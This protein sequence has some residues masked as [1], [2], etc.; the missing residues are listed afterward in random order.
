M[1]K[2]KSAA[3]GGEQLE[4]NAAL[5]Q[6]RAL[7]GIADGKML[8]RVS[9]ASAGGRQALQ[10]P[11]APSG[12]DLSQVTARK[13]LDETAFFFPHLI[14]DNEGKVKL[15]FTMP[16]A[17]TQWRFLGFAH[18]NDLR[19]GYLEDKVVTAKDLMVQPN[20]PRFLREGDVLEFTVKVSN[21]SA[22]RQTGKVRLTLANARTGKPV[23]Q[24]LGI[25]EPDQSFELAA[26][27][28]QS[29]SWKLT[30]PDGAGVLTYKAVGSTGR[31][32]DGEE[33]FLPV[34]SRRTLVTES[35]P[36][37]IR[38]PATKKFEFTRLL[39]SAESKTLRNQSL[40]VQ[41]VS[42]PSW[43]AVMALPYLMESP[44]ECTEQTFNRLYANSLARHIANSD[45][46][47]HRI[48]EQWRG[49]PALQSPLEKNQDLKSVMLEETPWLRQAQAESQA[50]RNV[51]ILFEDNRLNDETA[52][53]LAKLSQQQMGDGAWPWFPG[54]PPCDYITLYITTG[55]GRLHHLGVKVDQSPA[56][57]SL[58][59]LDGWINK[60]Y[61]DILDAEKLEKVQKGDA[62]KE[63]SHLSH[64][65]ALYLYGRSFFL[66]DKPIAAAHK[67]AVDFFLAQARKYWLQLADRQS[68][69]QLAIA[70]KRF[71]DQTTP[72]DIMRS[73]LE[74]S[75]SDEEL[76][77]FWRDTEML[78]WWYRA[79][80]ETQALMIEALD[81]VLDDAKAVEDCKV[82][83]LK[84]KQTQDWKTTKATA[85]AVYALLL[86]GAG[87]LASDELVEVSLGG[88]T[89]EP[90]NVE[91]GTGFYE[92]RLVRSE[93]TPQMGHITVKK[94]DPGVAWGSVH[95]Q[96]LEDMSKVTSYADTPLKLTKSLYIR[97]Y[98]KKGPVFG[99][100]CRPAQGRRRAGGPHHPAD[101]PRHGV[102]ALEGPSRERHGAGQCVV[103]VSL[104]G[105]PGLLRGDQ[106]HGQ[107]LLHRLPAEGRLR[108]RV[109]HSGCPQG[110][111]PD[112]ICLDPVHV[113]P[114]VQ[115]PLR[116]PAAGGEIRCGSRKIAP[117]AVISHILTRK[118]GVRCVLP[119]CQ[120]L[121]RS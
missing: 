50:R 115:Q 80:I 33:G 2:A 57:R 27:E 87:Q 9:E 11:S 114:G 119:C 78:V 99:A 39:K 19:S 61:H 82:W 110:Q 63:R 46:K 44:Y 66:D 22:T 104:P 91:A 31:I 38:G 74:R 85:D 15:E 7:N 37:P 72:R 75:V 21:Q 107:P 96:Y 81:E 65:I 16:E 52:R 1:E 70:L 4:A 76:G 90:E 40:T 105:R 51:G 77:T 17:L 69:G 59:R 49:T 117:V 112:R 23:D 45:P 101:R 67:E 86:R 5:R 24:L 29:F 28:S 94:T 102:R 111:V 60:M 62:Y 92:Q 118:R 42:N 54:G 71:G 32:S 83:L 41:M 103:A 98:T 89:I 3:E 56:L 10:S 93:I 55:F 13:N 26:K 48:F 6:D 64:T 73:I 34:L 43:Y 35:L 106:G 47:I 36:L 113:R 25:T 14:S 30:V 120:R 100:R 84:Q 68:Q 97:E 79:P 18:D 116:E 58:A 88:K 20:P 12:P 8:Q 108:V 95:W 109:C 121:S 53:L